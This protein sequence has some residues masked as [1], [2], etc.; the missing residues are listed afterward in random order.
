MTQLSRSIIHFFPFKP[1]VG[2][3]I[4]ITKRNVL[5]PFYHTVS[6]E[7]LPHINNLYPIRDTKLFLQDLDFLLEHYQP[8]TINELY[9][10]VSSGNNP[11]KPVFHLTFDDG[12]KE[13]Y[14]II[15]P[16]L[17]EKKVPA[18][19]FVNTAFID[20]KNMF[21]RYQV[22]LIIESIKA[23]EKK[24]LHDVS[25][26]LGITTL[27]ESA[28]IDKLRTF[29]QNSRNKL[30]QLSELLNLDFTEFLKTQQPYMT[31]R[32]IENLIKRGFSIGSHGVMH[33]MFKLLSFNEQ[34]NQ[35][36]GSFNMLNKN[37]KIKGTYF[38]FPFSDEGVGKVFFEWFQEQGYML[39]FGISGMKDDFSKLHLHRIPM[40]GTLRPAETLIKAEYL[41]FILKAIVN[42]N[43]ITRV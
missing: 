33:P 3:L 6:D 1:S 38:S 27:K 5:L 11:L 17:E 9:K 22:S 19:V 12:L 4:K 16:I 34:K 30:I 32:Q 21:Y 43:K 18:T 28:I 39:S 2:T 8:I 14:T 40:E 36:E 23:L 42:K 31:T 26:L 24:Q 35:V 37:F 29:N 7:T 41:Y 20:N 10:I 13:F 15:V 25:N